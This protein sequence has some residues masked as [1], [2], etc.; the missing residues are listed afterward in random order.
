[1]SQLLIFSQ[2]S[3]HLTLTFITILMEFSLNDAALL[4]CLQCCFLTRLKQTQLLLIMTHHALWRL[5]QTNWRFGML[6]LV[7]YCLELS[8]FDLVLSNA[9]LKFSLMTVKLLFAPFKISDSSL[10]VLYPLLHLAYFPRFLL[11]HLLQLFTLFLLFSPLAFLTTG[12]G[13]WRIFMFLFGLFMKG[14]EWAGSF[15]SFG[16][17]FSEM[18]IVVVIL[19]MAETVL[20]RTVVF[21]GVRQWFHAHYARSI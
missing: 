17:G 15:G 9:R 1:M 10:V 18:E 14:V 3:F 8:Y 19:C 21:L 11:Q 4:H 20:S 16:F 13:L 5:L 12:F 7:N 6:V 2:Q